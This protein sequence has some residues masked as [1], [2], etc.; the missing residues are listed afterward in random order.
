M[1]GNLILH[2][3]SVHTGGGLVLL[4]SLLL[5]WP[6]S[7]PL[8]ALLDERARAT[9]PLPPR[10]EVVWVS[11]SV[12]SR[13]AAE[14]R[15]RD[16]ARPGDTVLCFH[17]LPP[18]LRSAGKV[19]VFKQNRLHVD[20]M[21]LRHFAP[22]VALRLALERAI[23]RRFR[24]H[25]AEYIVQTPS[26]ARALRLWHGGEPTVTVLPFATPVGEPSPVGAVRWDFVYVAD[27]VAHKNHRRLLR[28]WE[29]LAQQGFRLRLALTLGTRDQSLI[30][31]VAALR[32]KSGI[33]VH[34]VGVG[35]PAHVLALYSASRALIYP[36][37]GESLGLPLLEATQLGLPIVAA[38]LD[39][40]RDVCEPNQTF[41][42][43]SPV[44][45]A[46]AVRRFLARPEPPLTVA[47]PTQLL[48]ALGI[49]AEHQPQG[50]WAGSD[51]ANP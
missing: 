44:S 13:L 27:G 50:S 23:A 43:H 16:A 4:R 47:P 15:L 41:D 3:P 2:A 39:Y 40:V 25:V 42:P 10:A 32:L 38:E 30:D 21:P 8:V 14:W 48:A 17:G 20:P 19:V 12:G 34:N 45:I 46:R 5:A 6:R 9:L 26:M 24:R 28:A 33:E 18:L 1:S 49:V 29:L 31:E 36:S 35:S 37:L 11:P 51:A 7:H 22:R